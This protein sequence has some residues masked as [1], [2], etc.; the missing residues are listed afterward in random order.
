[1]EGVKKV[2]MKA[3][4]IIRH[5]AQAGFLALLCAISVAAQD[6]EIEAGRRIGKIE[7]SMTRQQVHQKLGKPGGSYKMGR[8]LVGEYW[9]SPTGTG[10]DVRIVYRGGKV[11]QIKVTSPSFKTPEG[12]TTE[13]GLAEVRQSY[14]NLKKTRHFVHGSG[15]GLI[16]Y[17]DD[18]RR[19]ITF[20]FTAPDSET[21]DFKPYAIVVHLPGRRN[22]PENDEELVRYK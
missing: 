11:I 9:S 2:S 5:V 19:G 6:F 15:G 8:G 4:K 7:L 20:E 22:I 13:S 17:Y 14:Q 18:V 3:I 21:P 1:M 12:L 16:E 10:N